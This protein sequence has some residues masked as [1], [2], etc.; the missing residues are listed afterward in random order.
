MMGASAAAAG[1]AGAAS[2]GGGKFSP[3]SASTGSN[4]AA[5]GA[6]STLDEDG[7]AGFGWGGTEAA[8]PDSFSIGRDRRAGGGV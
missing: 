8:L 2:S 3:A 1:A 6:R 7:A 4:G 5:S